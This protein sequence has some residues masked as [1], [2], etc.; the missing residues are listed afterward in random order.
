MRRNDPSPTGADVTAPT[1][2]H[3]FLGAVSIGQDQVVFIDRG[4]EDNLSPGDIFTVYRENRQGY[5]PV[6]LG[7]LSVL[8]VKRR[9]A[10]ARILESRYPIYLGDRLELK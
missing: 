1:I 6:V 7:E 9:S 4:A 5:P 2:I 3:A 10:T 8:S